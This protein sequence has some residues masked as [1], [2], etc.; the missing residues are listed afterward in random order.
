MAT[1]VKFQPFVENLAEGKFDFTSDATCTP[2]IA[3]SA[4]APTNTW[5]TLAE[6]TE[7]AYTNL[8][9]RVVTVTSS[10]Q[11]A[12]T[13]KLV[14]EDLTLT[15]S[16]VVADWRYVILYDDDAASDE[17]IAYWDKGATVSMTSGDTVL[18]NFDGTN[19]VFQLV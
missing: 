8:S 12:G 14:L 5:G 11:T 19:G 9:A 7:V 4:G 17:L 15:A 18:I 1:F 10:S 2:T 16:G 6:C 3:L 13:Y